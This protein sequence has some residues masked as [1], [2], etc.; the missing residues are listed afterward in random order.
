MSKLEYLAATPTLFNSGTLYSQLSSCFVL[1]LPDSIEG[2]A[3]GIKDVMFLEKHSGGIGMNVSRLRSADSI[4]NSIQGKSS[5]PIPFL[6]MFDSVV[7][8]VSQG[9]RRRGSMAIYIE[10]WHLNI[11]D[12]ILLKNRVG[13]E[14]QR[15]RVINTVIWANDEFLR[16]AKEDKSWYLF[17]PSEVSDLCDLHGEAFS[18]RY[19]EY[20]KMAKA[21]VDDILELQARVD[22]LEKTQVFSYSFTTDETRA[23]VIFDDEYIFITYN[24]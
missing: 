19:I 13:D 21:V 5:G 9:G 11:D 16:R 10:P 6:K 3:D 2:I 22:F 23:R 1:D 18:E 8:G 12:F 15:L 20:I 4:I 14:T 7:A 17:D 24:L